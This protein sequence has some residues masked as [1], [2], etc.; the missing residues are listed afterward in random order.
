MDKWSA[1]G[2]TIYDKETGLRIALVDNKGWPNER[3]EAHARLIA[4]VPEMYRIIKVLYDYMSDYDLDSDTEDDICEILKF[5]DGK[6]EAKE[7]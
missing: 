6:Q 3:A 5:I 4:A 7:C 2:F 1:K